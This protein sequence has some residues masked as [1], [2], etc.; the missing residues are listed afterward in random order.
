MER[1]TALEAIK[2][3]STV[4]PFCTLPWRSITSHKALAFHQVHKEIAADNIMW[5]IHINGT[6][7]PLDVL[8]KFLV[9]HCV[10]WSLIKKPF[11]FWHPSNLTYF[12]A[13]TT[14]SS[15][16]DKPKEGYE[17]PRSVLAF[18][19][20]ASPSG[21]STSWRLGLVL[22]SVPVASHS[23]VHFLSFIKR[24]G[25]S[26]IQRYGESFRENQK[27]D[28]PLLALASRIILF[29]RYRIFHRRNAEYFQSKVTFSSN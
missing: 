13:V 6:E 2:V 23:D 11:P 18:T 5:F 21:Y 1:P 28:P 17:C 16:I 3:W 12:Y 22:Y 27:G 8:S 9:G 15:K 20:T 4:T 19:A 14:Y 7:N 29:W 24:F 25:D 10:F 26:E